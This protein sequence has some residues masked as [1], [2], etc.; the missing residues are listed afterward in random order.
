MCL[1]IVSGQ[2]NSAKAVLC[3]AV[4]LMA[5]ALVAQTPVFTEFPV[6]GQPFG[7]TSGPDGNLWFTES[8]SNKIGRI[9]I[10]GVYSEFSVPSANSFP[11][12]IIA[13]PD[14]NLWFTE[15]LSNK[16]GRI[17]PAGAITEFTIPTTVTFPAAITVG[18]DGN[19]WFIEGGRHN[20]GRITTNGV[21]TEFLVPTNAEANGITAG[22]DA[23]IW[24]T[25][26][27]VIDRRTAAGVITGFSLPA[28]TG[29]DAI[30]S[31]PDGNLWY[32]DQASSK[33]GRMTTGGVITIFAIPSPDQ[34][35]PNCQVNCGLGDQPFQI[36]L[37]PDGAL[38][39]TESLGQWGL[40]RI[41]TSG[42]ITEF[43]VP[44]ANSGPNGI[45]LGPDGN[46]WFTEFSAYK[47]GRAA[48]PSLSQPTPVPSSLLLLAMGL[49][50][51]MSWSGWRALRHHSL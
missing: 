46:I 13:G 43:R 33:I 27:G 47:I 38:W 32:L 7:I 48:L 34:G 50:A 2:N 19:L 28:L 4:L 37:G 1:V 42:V 3:A 51:L 14:G 6:P 17:T 8:I 21:I 15:M 20:I 9:T 16:I 44:T 26:P 45:T 23:N 30:T 49:L 39:F 35:G 29:A 41:T 22:P 40:G 24:F 12:L 10:A 11:F 36:I 31:G 18:P 25:A 5:G